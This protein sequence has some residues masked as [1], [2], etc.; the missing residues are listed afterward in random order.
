MRKLRDQFILSHI[1]PFLLVMPIAGLVILY[2]VEAQVLLGDLSAD[3]EARASLIAEAVA[4]QPELLADRPA[5]EQFAREAALRAGAQVYLLDPA[6]NVVAAAPA[7]AE[8]PDSGLVAESLA[9]PEGTRVKVSYTIAGQEGEA[10][11]VVDINEQI[12][13]LIGVRESITGLADSFSPLRRL[14]L[15]TIILGMATGAL[16]GYRL[17]GKMAQPISRTVNAVE[18]IAAGTTTSPLPDEGPLELRRLAEAVNTLA[19]RLQSLE[20]MRRRSL[21]NIVHELGRPLGAMKAAV[22]VLRGPSGED[23]A[24]REELLGGVEHELS[25]MEPLLN[26]LLQLHAEA[27]GERRLDRRV[28]NLSEWLNEV[29]PPWR[30]AV[31]ATGLDWVADIPP[32]LPEASIDAPRMA[33]VVGNLLSNAVKYTTSGGVAV[34]ATA[35]D[36]EVKISVADTGP[37]IAPGEQ[38]RVFEP[39]YRGTTPQRTTEGLGVGLAIARGLAEAHGGR[40]TLESAPGRGSVFTVYLP[41]AGR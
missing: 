37:G 31:T 30:E 18:Q 2:L 12:V 5:A 33:Q 15:L 41:R 1:L 8:P 29:L 36:R 22:Q 3:L 32:D 19:A 7:P 21:A 39:F 34:F 24:V 27:G 26:D 40:I 6:G 9:A 14:V 10:I 35:D 38:G 17:A 4:L 25:G 16:I 11:A 28:V 23:A 20:E 13:G